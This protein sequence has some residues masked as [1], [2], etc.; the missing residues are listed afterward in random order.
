MTAL[1][2]PSSF[3]L[4]RLSLGALSGAEQSSISAH[5]AGCAQCRARLEAMERQAASFS[6]SSHSSPARQR[7]V[8]ADQAWRRNA[9]RAVLLP[10]AA[11]VA[12]LVA[13]PWKDSTSVDRPSPRQGRS[14]VE[15]RPGTARPT[16]KTLS[17]RGQQVAF[18]QGT[19]EASEDEGA[20]RPFVLEHTDV[21]AEVTGFVSAV[22][23][24]QR[25][26]NPFAKPVEAVYVFPLPENAAVD[27]MTLT[28]GTRVIRATI[29]KREEARRQYEQAKSQGRRAALLDQERP[30]IF[31]QSVANLLPGESVQVS[32]RYVAPLR[33]DDGAYTF[34][35]PM[36]VGP[37]YMPGA[38]LAGDSQGTGTMPDTDRV[39]D[40]SRISPP[41]ERTG[42]DLSVEVRL[43]T[44]A[45]IE[46]LWSVSHQLQ[47]ERTSS[48]R[49][50]I[51]LDAA[52]RVPNKDFILRWKV[53]G[54]E[55][56]A[57]VVS[58]GGPE[59]TFALMLN[60]EAQPSNEEVLPKE[61]VFV[62]DTSCS[63]NGQPLEA[64]KQAMALAMK[65]MNPRDSF[66][67]ID[68]ADRASSFHDS[69]LPNTPENVTKALGY[70][71]ALPSGGGTNQLDGIRRA[72]DRPADG[73]RLRVVL[74]MT[75]GFIGNEQE[76]FQETQ[77]LLGNGRVFGFGIGASVNHF[78][79]ARLSEEGRGFY[80]YVRTD[81]DPTEAVSRFVRRIAKPLMTDVTIDWGGLQV[82]DVLPRKVPDLFDAQPVVLLGRYRNGGPATLTLRGRVGAKNVELATRVN[83]GVASAASSGLTSMWARARI[84]E[85]DRLQ[86]FGQFPEAVKEITTLGLEHHLVTAHTSF[87]A[88]DSMPVTDGESTQV[89]VP[90]ETEEQRG[91]PLHAYR[92]NTI[93]VIRGSA[94]PEPPP[95]PP[96]TIP[97]VTP[98]RPDPTTPERLHGESGGGDRFDNLF[99]DSKKRGGEG[100]F[101]PDPAPTNQTKRSLDQ[102]DILEG[103]LTARSQWQAC[104]A[105]QHTLQ[106]SVTNGKVVMKWTIGTD[107]RV[108]SVSVVPGEFANSPFAACLKRVIWKLQF[109]PH[110]V[111]G[112]PVQFPFKF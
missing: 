75:D 80:Q 103:V 47:S 50:V 7:V 22:T 36:V 4:E 91:P 85:V 87:V 77:R 82:V 99:G 76:I 78:L 38:P 109:P 35:F 41:L 19:L 40:A 63:M 104:I 66:M 100:R 62:I 34:N 59:G 21:V 92:Y 15:L 2:H 106:P 31:T 51:T 79:L 3:T 48:S 93:Q 101:N 74:L 86:K 33:F 97:L 29:Q 61:M 68:F 8:R 95:A 71:N 72:L 11:I 18:G 28:A 6:R 12:L 105:E 53:S 55:T 65:Q 52:D 58:T 14:L 67:L 108:K 81:E 107:G 10:A 49:A 24:T 5:V 20:S 26:K 1:K 25:F 57:A 56:R 110:S 39:D 90:T 37:R 23:V 69:P 89:V 16:L 43:E 84:E 98:P 64:A 102:A 112:E 60:P 32:L 9:M 96:T 111:A 83:L 17:F 73:D 13:A 27:E 94:E 30:N 70:L 88:V 54:P 45:V 42:R 44:G 46:E